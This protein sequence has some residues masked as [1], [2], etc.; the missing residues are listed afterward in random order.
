MGNQ[1][2]L[3]LVQAWLNGDKEAGRILVGESYD[4][5]LNWAFKLIYHYSIPEGQTLAGEITNEAFERALRKIKDYDASSRFYTWVCGFVGNC[6]KEY[7]RKHA[8]YIVMD[9]SQGTN[10]FL[11]EAEFSSYSDPETTYI[12]KEEYEAVKEAFFALKKEYQDILYKRLILEMSYKEISVTTEKS[13]EALES[14]FRRA[15]VALRN[16]FQKNY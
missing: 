6:L 3:T 11:F 1:R 8:K 12:H 4:R 2:D 13:V 9:E 5:V 16:E 7:C 14:I 15:L 10:A